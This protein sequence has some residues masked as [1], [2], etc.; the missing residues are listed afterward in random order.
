ME[1]PGQS[2]ILRYPTDAEIESALNLFAFLSLRGTDMSATVDTITGP[3]DTLRIRRNAADAYEVISV[4]QGLAVPK[5][6][7]R[8]DLN[9][10]FVAR[11]LP[12]VA[13][14]AGTNQLQID[15]T[16][17]NAGPSARLQVDSVVNGS[18]LN[19][20]V[21]FAAGGVTVTGITVASVKAA[22]YPT[23][24][25]INVSTAAIVALSSWSLLSATKQAALVD[26]VAEVIA[27]SF[28]E[29]GAVLLSFAYGVFSKMRSATF[30]PGGD[31]VGLPAGVAA[32]F[33]QD[34]G[35]SVFS[36]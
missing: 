33:L 35:V 12:F 5:T 8:D 25:T 28:V 19:T 22:V 4:T 30:Q 15:T 31:R 18:T 6:T 13:S 34:D 26:A 24:T 2:R 11:G 3:D 21:G 16:D 10:A 7:I 9:T 23:P 29:T 36:L 1:P 27:P 14:V 20:A 17:D 32:A